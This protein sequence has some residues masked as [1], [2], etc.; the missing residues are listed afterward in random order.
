L[1]RFNHYSWRVKFLEISW[2][3]PDFF[4]AC[5]AYEHLSDVYKSTIFPNLNSLTWLRTRDIQHCSMFMHSHISAFRLRIPYNQLGLSMASFLVDAAERMPLL[6][7][8][9][10]EQKSPTS[11]VNT[12][13]VEMIPKLHHLRIFKASGHL[14]PE[15]FRKLATLRHLEYIAAVY[16]APEPH[17]TEFP[18]NLA[19]DSF[20]NLT[21]LKLTVRLKKLGDVLQDSQRFRSL[22]RLC[23]QTPG[24]D[25]N[26]DIGITAPADLHTFLSQ[27]AAACAIITNIY[28]DLQTFVAPRQI[29]PWTEQITI[30]HIAPLFAIP[31]IRRF[32]LTHT[33]PLL[34]TNDDLLKLGQAWPLLTCLTL[35]HEP[36]AL[37]E[38]L[39]TLA[40]LE[41]IGRQCPSLE[42]L[43]ININT[44]IRL[45]RRPPHVIVPNL[46][47]LHI[48]LS[49]LQNGTKCMDS[50]LYLLRA[51]PPTTRIQA[52]RPW[53]YVNLEY[54]DEND[55]AL[56]NT[57]QVINHNRRMWKW[58][59]F[60]V[61]AL[62]QEI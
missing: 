4:H 42:L 9:H 30:S 10:L 29:V 61:H 46:K 52:R 62:R 3:S 20:S 44:T 31:T 18:D 45:P 51:L 19:S 22:D 33:Y 21:R 23:I 27:L 5:D 1:E 58:I 57:R 40:M 15:L 55:D 28:L 38:P 17:Q 37:E 36:C 47:E 12:Q 24:D 53:W 43:A 16:A 14:E 8:L 48:G 56:A 50:I 13:V 7:T 26:S 59:E 39:L 2:D 6:R 60:T 25:G 35:N 34:I 32:H 49:T 11:N 41:I 54:E